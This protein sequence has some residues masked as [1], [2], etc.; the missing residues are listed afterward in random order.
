[1]TSFLSASLE[2]RLP[3]FMRGF[4][5]VELAIVLLIVSLLVGGVMM[6]V[7]T[8]QEIQ[9]IKDS[10]KKLDEIREALIGYALA[11]NGALPCPSQNATSGSESRPGGT[12]CTE[13]SPPFAN[14]YVGFLPWETLGVSQADAW[15]HRFRY[16]VTKTFAN[17][18]STYD[19]NAVGSITVDND[20]TAPGALI[21]DAVAVVLSHGARAAYAYTMGGQQVPDDPGVLNTDEDTNGTQGS[22]FVSR[23]PAAPGA[24]PP[25]AFDDIVIWLPPTILK[26]RLAAAGILPR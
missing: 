6:A 12:T 17:K 22:S 15:G 25:G 11:N 19:F 26:A 4:T 13:S 10:E 9:R 16:S 5:L 24:P 20:S 21:S 3:G 7:S 2:R 1:M 14:V 8:Q 23:P 18:P